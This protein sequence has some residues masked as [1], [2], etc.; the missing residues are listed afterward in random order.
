MLGNHSSSFKVMYEYYDTDDGK[1]KCGMW[2]QKL[3]LYLR[4]RESCTGCAGHTG[5]VCTAHTRTHI[6]AGTTTVSMRTG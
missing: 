5:C 6:H 1:K 2:P 3:P 4:V